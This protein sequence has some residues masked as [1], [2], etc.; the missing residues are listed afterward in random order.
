MRVNKFIVYLDGKVQMRV[1]VSV[2]DVNVYVHQKPQLDLYGVCFAVTQ[3][4]PT[5]YVESKAIWA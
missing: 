4:I 3:S 1:S 2:S 5:N